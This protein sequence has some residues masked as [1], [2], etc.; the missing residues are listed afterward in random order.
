MVD[1]DGVTVADPDAAMGAPFSVTLVAPLVLHESV[2]DC[3]ALIVVGV[4]VKDE[5]TGL[6]AV[7]PPVLA[8]PL[9]TTSQS[10]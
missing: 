6:E 7:E 1:A 4:A 3:P 5:I 10:E 2:D 8:V 9:T